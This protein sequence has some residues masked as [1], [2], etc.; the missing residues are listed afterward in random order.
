MFRGKIMRERLSVVVSVYN[1]ELSL[2]HF[3]KTA[4]DVLDHCDVDYEVI[5]VNDGSLD[6]SERILNE[7]ANE[8]A[9]VKVVSFARNF[10]H[11]AAMIAGID[12]ASGDYIVCMDADLQH[13]PASIPAI[14][15]KFREGYDVVSM[16]RTANADAGIFKRLTSSAFY[17]V[18]NL[19]S[20]VKFE[21][22]SSDFFAI[23]RRVADVL[24]Q[25]YR[26]KVRYL[27]GYV[28]SVGF[29]R[30]TLEFQ[31]SSRIA[32]ESKYSFRKLLNFS[33]H[34]LCSFSDL[35]LKL[36][37]Y[38]GIIVALFGIIL[39]IYSIYQKIFHNTPGGYTTIVV[40]LC[41]LFATTLIVI[42]II[43]EYISILFAEIKNRPIYIVKE[44]Q[45]LH[46]SK[47]DESVSKNKMLAQ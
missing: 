29:R 16:I 43:G 27:R 17:K 42:G 35:P 25:D 21:N 41:F 33:I 24:R 31:A 13:P 6:Q 19:F 45:N 40:A 15:Q 3:W 11:E 2:Q 22:N 20:P 32:G 26:E 14:I 8:N 46:G 36:G 7:M 1:E 9:H 18:L 37:L 30:T 38:S 44:T 10:G 5:F 34:T 12:Y 4:A 28:Q 23:S 39:M 47:E